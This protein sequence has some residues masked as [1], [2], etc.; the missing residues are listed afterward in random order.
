MSDFLKKLDDGRLTLLIMKD[1]EVIFSS[2]MDGM[3]PL[4]TAINTIEPSKLHGSIV[5]DKMVGKAAALIICLFKAKEAQTHIMSQRAKKVLDK[6]AVKY[7]FEETVPELL[8]KAGT[9]ICP[10]EKAVLAVDDPEEGL[11]KLTGEVKRLA[12]LKKP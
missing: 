2:K 8:N 4:L 7:S 5:A 6:Y 9:D 11:K 12:A 1:G 10:F 3:A